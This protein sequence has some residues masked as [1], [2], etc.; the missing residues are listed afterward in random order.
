[1]NATAIPGYPG[2]VIP[3]GPRPS[4]RRRQ[5]V[6]CSRPGREAVERRHPV[7]LDLATRVTAVDAV[8][9]CQ[10]G[11]EVVG[12]DRDMPG[13]QFAACSVAPT[14]PVCLENVLGIE[15]GSDGPDVGV[16]GYGVVKERFEGRLS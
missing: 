15:G 8:Q 1:M 7:N 2:P 9:K 5:A 11:V 10:F 13:L 16:V 14:V 4:R 3:T 6:P 12:H